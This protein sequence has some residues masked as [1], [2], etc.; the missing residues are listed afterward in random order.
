MSRLRAHP[1]TPALFLAPSLVIL[2]VFFL[3][4]F[5]QVIYYS[6][7]SYNPFRGAEWVGLE[8][9]A[10]LFSSRVFWIC[11]GNSF[12]YLLVTPVLILLSL[13]AAMLVHSKL[14][15]AD[16]LR[17]IL[18]LP[19]VTPTIVAAVAWRLLLNE[20]A[21]VINGTI[22]MFG[23]EPIRWLSERPWTLVSSMLV[24]MWKGFGF[25]MMVFLAGLLAV[26]RELH[27]AAAIDGAGRLKSF[28][29]VTLPSIWP[30]VTLVVVISSI[31]ALK[32]FD[33]LFVTIRGMPIDHL[34]AVPLV[35]DTAFERFRFGY[36]CA[37]GVSLFLI[38]LVFSL[39]NLKLSSKGGGDA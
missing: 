32:V 15:G 22:E 5:V 12:L 36:A 9:Y 21:G 13:A 34:T 39:I 29:H 4:S 10:Q 17:L 30:V 24:T 3:L 2:G 7:T 28:V 18:F 8:N 19:V 14:R 35:Y 33:E 16:A 11:L 27:E 25:Y 26:P 23:G 20:D 37:V 1:I 6:M 31:S 38:I